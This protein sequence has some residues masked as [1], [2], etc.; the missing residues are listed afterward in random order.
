MVARVSF[1][2]KLLTL[3]PLLLL[4][5]KHN[6]QDQI[7]QSTQ[8]KKIKIRVAFFFGR[9]SRVLITITV[10][11]VPRNSTPGMD[12]ESCERCF[13]KSSLFFDTF[14]PLK[15]QK[16]VITPLELHTPVGGT[17]HLG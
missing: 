11:M 2:A 3:H 9:P 8:E 5:G 12:D 15:P 17:E 1:T 7:G 13:C 6:N 10:N 4:R 14:P 16:G